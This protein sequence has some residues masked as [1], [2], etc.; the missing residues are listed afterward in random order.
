MIAS[1]LSQHLMKDQ[2]VGVEVVNASAV[3]AHAEMIRSDMHREAI[4]WTAS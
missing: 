2:M 1:W 3:L 4:I